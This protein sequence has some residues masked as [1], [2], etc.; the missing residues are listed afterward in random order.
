[1][2]RLGNAE[3]LPIGVFKGLFP[4]TS[5]TSHGGKHAVTPNTEIDANQTMSME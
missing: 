2:K 4:Y 1:M 5:F 3:A